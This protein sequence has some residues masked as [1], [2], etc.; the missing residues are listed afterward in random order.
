MWD[1]DLREPGAQTTNGD[2]VGGCC[3]CSDS[4]KAG[5]MGWGE[6]HGQEW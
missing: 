6:E 2:G 1:M 3:L 4:V 5:A